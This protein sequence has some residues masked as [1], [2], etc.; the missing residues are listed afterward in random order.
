MRPKP[1]KEAHPQTKAAATNNRLLGRNGLGPYIERPQDFPPERVIWY[2]DDFVAIRDLYPKAQIHTLLLPR[3]PAKTTLHPTEAFEDVDFRNLVLRGV[4]KLKSQVASELRR[5]YGLFSKL[6]APRVAAMNSDDPPDV[7]PEGRDWEKS[8]ATGYHAKP[9]MSHLHIHVFSVDRVSECLKDRK[10]YNSFATP[11]LIPV[12]DT[13]LHA[14]DPR[15]HPGREGYLDQDFL[16]WRCGRNFK[17]RFT[18]LK[19]H[20]KDELEQWKRE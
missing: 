4:K 3:N 17:H 2:D 9:S 7:L 16:C 10:H 19:D 5:K 14:N 1:R 18:M 15:R 12:E 6:E 13:P 11:F 8:V 20:L